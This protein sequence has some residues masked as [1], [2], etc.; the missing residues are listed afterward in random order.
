M[1]PA[2]ELIRLMLV[3]ARS[4][5]DSRRRFARA[6]AAVVVAVAAGVV[7]YGVTQAL[8]PIRTV[9][10]TIVLRAAARTVRGYRIA[11][12]SDL[13]LGVL[14]GRDRTQRVVDLINGQQSDLVALAGD[15]SDGLP[16]ELV[17]ATSPLTELTAPDGVL[18]S[19]G[20]H[21]YYFDAAAWRA[22]LPGLRVDLLHNESR[23]IDRDGARL[24]VAGYQRLQRGPVR[25]RGRP[26]SGA[27]RPP[28]R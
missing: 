20:N 19:N 22:A 5:R 26:G 4:S 8:G 16:G 9:Q 25:R 17:E 21:E 18:F 27:G 28:A 6:A 12:A 23:V 15:L 14:N 10:A 3:L 13:H 7:G 24:L 2:T 11:L 1:L